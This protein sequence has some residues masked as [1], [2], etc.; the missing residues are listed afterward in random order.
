MIL[1]QSPLY[2]EIREKY[3]AYYVDAYF[4][5]TLRTFTIFTQRDGVPNKTY[6]AICEIIRS[7]ESYVNEEAI[8]AAVV[9]IVKINDLPFPMHK[10]GLADAVNGR[11]RERKQAVRDALIAITV[12]EVKEA[13]RLLNDGEFSVSIAASSKAVKP[14]EG[15][16]VIDTKSLDN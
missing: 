4:A 12:D 13:A 16:E 6:K 14:L 1:K 7:A 10:R 3:G 9:E 8:D 11:K 15:F 5:S 2:S